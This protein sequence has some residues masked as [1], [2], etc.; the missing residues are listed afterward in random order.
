MAYQRLEH[1][2]GSCADD[3]YRKLSHLVIGYMLA[4]KVISYPGRYNGAYFGRR[5]GMSAN[6]LV[7]DLLAGNLAHSSDG[8]GGDFMVVNA[9]CGTD[10]L[11]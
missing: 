8:C 2:S 11:E 6:I 7:R 3:N 5:H 1:H 4:N 9:D 10:K